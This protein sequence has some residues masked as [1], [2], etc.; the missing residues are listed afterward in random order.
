MFCESRSYVGKGIGPW[1]SLISVFRLSAQMISVCSIS[2]RRARLDNR[3]C[4]SAKG[5]SIDQRDTQ[6][7]VAE[8]HST[9]FW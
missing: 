7:V 6:G 3:D 1:H 2:T 4:G 8:R 9:F 5:R